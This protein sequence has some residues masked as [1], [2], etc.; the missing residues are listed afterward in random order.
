M[1]AAKPEA[2][3][4]SC[5]VMERECNPLREQGWRAEEQCLIESGRYFERD[6]IGMMGRASGNKTGGGLCKTDAVGFMECVERGA[7]TPLV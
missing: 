5:C 7:A 4:L 2:P 6:L 1:C 3:G